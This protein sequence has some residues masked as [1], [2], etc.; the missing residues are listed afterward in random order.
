M[1]S[2]ERD[3][4]VQ[5]WRGVEGAE[6]KRTEFLPEERILCQNAKFCKTLRREMAW[7]MRI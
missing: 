6:G 1:D 2:A 4:C 5:L 7:R 3:F